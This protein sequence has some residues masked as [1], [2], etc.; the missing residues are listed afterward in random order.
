MEELSAY[1]RT[2]VGSSPTAPTI[3]LCMWLQRN[4]IRK[5]C[6]SIVL[7]TKKEKEYLVEHGYK[8]GSGEMLHHTWSKNRKYYL[9]ENPDVLLDLEEYRKQRI[10][11]R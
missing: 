11:K 3:Y 8:F 7:I 6:I 4:F 5:V 2:V 1:I 9:T 10:L